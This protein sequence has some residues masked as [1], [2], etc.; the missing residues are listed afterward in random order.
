[1]LLQDD[2]LVN[3]TIA[4]EPVGCPGRRPILTDERQISPVLAL[5]VE[6]DFRSGLELP[7]GNLRRIQFVIHPDIL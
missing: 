6:K 3:K 2:A 1:M 7:V 4:A 5:I